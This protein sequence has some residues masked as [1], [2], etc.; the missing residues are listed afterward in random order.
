MAQY[1]KL[2][3][4]LYVLGFKKIVLLTFPYDMCLIVPWTKVV[5]YLY[6]YIITFT[7]S[8]ELGPTFWATRKPTE[9]SQSLCAEVS[10]CAGI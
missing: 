10:L 6:I 5:T 7:C 3:G 2:N 4:M 9:F 1:H 8:W